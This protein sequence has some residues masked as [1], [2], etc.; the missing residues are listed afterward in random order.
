MTPN[1][2]IEVVD[3]LKPNSYSEEDK[4]RWIEELDGMV[5]RL[6][7]QWDETYLEEIEEKSKSEA[8]TEKEKEECA[9][10]LK[11]A[12]PYSYPED[13]DTELL[14]TAPFENVYPLY[15]EAQ[16][17]YYN[18]E[19]A[20]YNN[21]ASMFESQYREFKKAYIRKNKARG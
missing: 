10:I 13:M 21:S 14:I 5:R 9:E 2:A 1:K 18:R 4:L 7:F 12:K 20:N 17:D 11:K 15:L 19:Y 16:I 8:S 3:R 6:V